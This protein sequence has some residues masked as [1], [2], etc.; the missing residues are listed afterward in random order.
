[1]ADIIMS[2]ISEFSTRERA[3]KLEAQ[4]VLYGSVALSGYICFRLI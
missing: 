3:I 1:M 2:E 4:S